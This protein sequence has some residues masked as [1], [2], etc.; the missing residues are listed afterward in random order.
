[1]K[2]YTKQECPKCGEKTCVEGGHVEID[3]D[4]AWQ[5]ITCME[6][7]CVYVEVYKYEQTEIWDEEEG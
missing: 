3:G 2:V 5:R 7:G 6:C 1:M 4:R